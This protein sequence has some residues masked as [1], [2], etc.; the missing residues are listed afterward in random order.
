[1]PDRLSPE[2]VSAHSR[3]D[4]KERA[5]TTKI[6]D[7]RIGEVRVAAAMHAGVHTCD[8]DAPLTEVAA[9]MAEERIHC[10]V[11][12][13]GSGDGGPPWGIVSDLDLVAAAM[14]RDLDAQTA[15]G[16]AATPVL[17]VSPRETLERAAQLM[18]EHGSSHLIV[19]DPD[20]QLPVG[21]LST[22]DIAAVLAEKAR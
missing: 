14:V 7:P 3:R 21:V 15:A 20:Q 1:M 12:E 17:M 5:M 19:V 18:T 11:V 6:R 4:P 2:I 8:R 16:S 9:M 13:S 10:I 22:L